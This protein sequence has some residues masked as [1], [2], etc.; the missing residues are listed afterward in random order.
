MNRPIVVRFAALALAAGLVVGC[1][2]KDPRENFELWSNN[3]AGWQQ[4]QT[5][6]KDANNPMDLRALSLEILTQSGHPSKASQI[7]ASADDKEAIF[8]AMRPA[9][10]KLLQSPNEKLQ[11]NAK[12]VLFD[13]MS[14]ISEAEQIKTREI[15]AQ[16]GMGDFS[17]DEA[18]AALAD[19]L[20]KRLRPDEIEK[21]GPAGVKG[22]EV[23]LGKAIA[24]NEVL[25]F[26]QSV[27][28]PEAKQAIV[29]GLRRYHKSSSK[30]KVTSVELG[31]VQRTKHL[32]GLL[33]F[34]ELYERLSTAEH[35]DDKN[36]GNM[37]IAAAVQWSDEEDGRKLVVD[38]WDK[39]A[40]IFEKLLAGPNC[41]LRWWSVTQFTRVEKEKGLAKGLRGLPDDANYG[42]AEHAL[43]DVKLQI[44]D[45][46]TKDASTIDKAV[47]RPIFIASLS[48]ERYIER[49]VAVRCLMVDGS[50]EARAALTTFIDSRKKLKEEA[51]IDPL[52]VPPVAENFTL[53]EL[54]KVA[55]ELV[56][57]R[58]A[59]DK[60]LADAKITAKQA[61]FRKLYANFSFDR[62]GKA[63]AEFA[64]SMAEDKIKRDAAKG[65]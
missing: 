43:N 13:S 22:A 62:K 48:T 39:L 37:A 27:D 6:V 59:V 20:G 38:N 40:P 41:D 9:L 57:Y 55:V 32:D 34:F 19:K 36:A 26:L 51:V 61:E 33:Y 50:D 60:D 42:Q 10:E 44:T 24:K 49:I 1:G 54:A 46:C 3:E 31:F 52:I 8:V 56:D 64:E 5:Y 25:T 21:L 30:V 28:T 35:P 45:L 4:I 15:L 29:A 17:H 65:K 53:T 11:L 58:R 2:N 12:Q 63:L 14:K 16:W 47:T 23:L 7:A 18:T